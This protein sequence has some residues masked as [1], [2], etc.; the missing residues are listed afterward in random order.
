[1]AFL[2][3]KWED[4]DWIHLAVAAPCETFRLHRCQQIS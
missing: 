1:M 4:Q 2:K 3:R